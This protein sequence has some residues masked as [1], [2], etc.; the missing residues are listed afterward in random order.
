MITE[1]KEYLNI[2]DQYRKL[3]GV[4]P[5]EKGDP[6]KVLELINRVSATGLFFPEEYREFLLQY[7]GFD[8]LGILIYAAETRPGIHPGSEVFG[9]VETNNALKDEFFI[10]EDETTCFGESDLEGCTFFGESGDDIFIYD[11]KQRQFCIAGRMSMEYNECF[12]TFNDMLLFIF[13][14]EVDDLKE[15][16]AEKRATA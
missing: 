10:M 3:K 4:P 6:V 2:I 12:D 8:F 7:D 14:P 5:L 11:S 13:K 9:F 16:I 1:L 15:L